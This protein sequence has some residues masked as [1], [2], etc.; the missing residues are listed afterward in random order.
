MIVEVLSK[1]AEVDLNKVHEN[2]TGKVID[3]M[4]FRKHV[5][6]G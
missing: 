4:F 2:N 3:F 6:D 1:M 5:Y